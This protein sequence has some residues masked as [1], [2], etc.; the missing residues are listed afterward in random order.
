MAT[1]STVPAVKTAL[2]SLL[3]ARPGLAG[4]AVHYAWPGPQGSAEEIVLATDPEA[5]PTATVTGRHDVA[6][7]GGN[8]TKRDERFSLP[9]TIRVYQ[10]ET[11]S[12]VDDAAACEARAFE[13]LAEV[14]DLVATNPNLDVD[15]VLSARAGDWAAT[16]DPYQAGWQARIV[17]NIE[18]HA[19]LN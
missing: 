16:V 15:G 19:R 12:A 2:S 9:V 7:L 1:S 3:A 14:E 11:T 17:F 6:V 5:E 10:G 8:R 4:V 18:I 13:L